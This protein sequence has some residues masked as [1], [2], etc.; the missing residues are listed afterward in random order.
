MLNMDEM[1][2]EAVNAISA[3]MTRPR[4]AFRTRLF[5]AARSLVATG[6]GVALLP[7]L[8]CRP[9]SLEGGRIKA[10][11]VSGALSVVHVGMAWRKG[12]PLFN[13]ARGR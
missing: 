10:R 7:D 9:W 2:Q 12:S 3:L 6:A 4:I 11:D 8:V 5:K 13:R 1:K